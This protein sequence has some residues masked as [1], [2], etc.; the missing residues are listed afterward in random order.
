[1]AVTGR[2]GG[3]PVNTMNGPTNVFSSP[4][5]LTGNYD[6]FHGKQRWGDTSSIRFD[7]SASTTAWAFNETVQNGGNLW[8]TRG[9]AMQVN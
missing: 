6:P 8:G 9:A 1:M 2:L 7:P 5:P 3:D 4:S